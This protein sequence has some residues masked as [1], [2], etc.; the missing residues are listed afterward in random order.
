[1]NT[2]DNLPRST[3]AVALVG[4]ESALTSALTLAQLA[5]DADACNRLLALK[6]DVIARRR[7]IEDPT[8]DDDELAA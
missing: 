5:N 7:R 4:L 6:R 1:M 3:Q 8:F 2:V